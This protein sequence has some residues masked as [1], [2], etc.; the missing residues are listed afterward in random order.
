MTKTA[1]IRKYVRD[2]R[3]ISTI[4]IGKSINSASAGNNTP[5]Q[6]VPGNDPPKL[7]G[8]P[9]L[10]TMFK[11]GSFHKVM[12]TPSTLKIIVGENWGE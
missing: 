5:I 8:K 3:Q 2:T 7:V 12:Y 1:K 4:S 11:N 9:Y 6:V 10:K